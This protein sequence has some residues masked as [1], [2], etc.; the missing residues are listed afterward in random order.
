VVS[1]FGF[2]FFFGFGVSNLGRGVVLRLAR[3]PLQL[4]EVVLHDPHLKELSS[5]REGFWFR[6]SGF[7]FLVSGF[8][9]PPHPPTPTS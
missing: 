1:G 8:G 3:D 2:R 6:V 7:G 4:L 5:I 9:F